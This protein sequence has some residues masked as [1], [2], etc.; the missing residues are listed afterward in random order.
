MGFEIDSQICFCLLGNIKLD[1]IFFII[2]KLISKTHLKKFFNEYKNERLNYSFGKHVI[3][4][5]NIHDTPYLV[6]IFDI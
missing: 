1:I 5:T 2:Y 3:F 4:I 6:K